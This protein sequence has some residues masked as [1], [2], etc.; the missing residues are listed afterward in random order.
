MG[1]GHLL[2]F[3][4]L[5]MMNTTVSEEFSLVLPGRN[6]GQACKVLAR[7]FP[8]RTKLCRGKFSA[9]KNRFTG[10]AGA[11]AGGA[12]GGQSTGPEAWRPLAVSSEACVPVLHVSGL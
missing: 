4:A 9:G 5:E 11:G 12:G 7:Q 6:Q 8:Q 1:S 2:C 10:G 3:S